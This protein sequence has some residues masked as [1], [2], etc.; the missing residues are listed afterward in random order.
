MRETAT[1]M[2]AF[3]A[4][5]L[6]LFD[7]STAGLANP[8][9]LPIDRRPFL[10]VLFGLR[11]GELFALERDVRLV[12]GRSDECDIRIP[13]ESVSRRHCAF[14]LLANGLEVEDLESRNGTFVGEKR[15]ERRVLAAEEI[16]RLGGTSVLKYS[17]IDSVEE[18]YRARMHRAAL[19][20]PLTMMFNRRHFENRLAAEC[21]ACRRHG[22][23]LILLLADIDDFKQI[24]DRHGHPAGDTVIRGVAAA[25]QAN[26]RTEDTVFRFGGE[27]FAIL[28]R[29]TTLEGAVQLGDRLRQAVA[30]L[31]FP[32]EGAQEEVSVTV[33]L[34]VAQFRP[35]PENDIVQRTDEALYRAKHQGKNQVVAEPE[36]EGA[37]KREPRAQ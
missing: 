12:V 20:D 36:P 19:L 22:R 24:N 15:V 11:E 37:A 7:D 23:P 34:G 33:S 32:V 17:L 26:L 3:R 25:L 10:V 31:H 6:D 8:K 30:A 29:E 2:E 27:E 18:E 5:K 14:T 21:A 4:G 9:G 16:V 35:A 13:D 28:A 1:D